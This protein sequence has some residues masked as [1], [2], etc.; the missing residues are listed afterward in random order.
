VPRDPGGKK[1]T[2]EMILEETR[3]PCDSF[4]NFVH[5]GTAISGPRSQ[6]KKGSGNPTKVETETG[7]QYPLQWTENDL[8]AAKKH[9]N[10]VRGKESKRPG[11]SG[12]QGITEE[13]DM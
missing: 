2:W 4:L 10:K 5:E 13:D 1:N 6:T 8:P 9:G 11:S 3:S 7:L 12:A